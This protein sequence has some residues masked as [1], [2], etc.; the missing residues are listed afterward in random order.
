LVKEKIHQ[1]AISETQKYGHVTYFWNGNKSGYIDPNF[2]TYKEIL[3]DV[4]PFD[5]APKMKAR[6]ITDEL[7]KTMKSGQYKFLRVNYPNGDM[8]GHTGKFKATVE[9][10]EFLDTCIK[11]IIDTAKGLNSV[12]FIT[13]DHGNSDEMYQLDKK[14]NVQKQDGQPVAKTSHTLNPVNFVVFDPSKRFTI[15]KDISKP[16]LANVAASILYALDYEAPEGYKP[17]LLE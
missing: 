7:I 3:S 8:V 17:G 4:I 6:E 13:A 12:V 1:Y 14:G 15:R 2:E 5:Q 9:S 10:L 16:G 11:D